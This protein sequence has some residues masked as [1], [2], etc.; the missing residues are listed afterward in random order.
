MLLCRKLC[1]IN[2]LTLCNNSAFK[3]E[4][5]AYTGMQPHTI[6]R[7]GNELGAQR[8]NN[9]PPRIV[10]KSVYPFVPQSSVLARPFPRGTAPLPCG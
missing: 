8:L 1:T 2:T 4:G 5:W 3:K 7:I 10:A 6:I 9:S